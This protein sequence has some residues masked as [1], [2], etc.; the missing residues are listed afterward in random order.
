MSEKE[1]KG[2][3]VWQWPRDV[4]QWK[5][6]FEWLLAMTM[7]SVCALLHGVCFNVQVKKYMYPVEH[8]LIW[9]VKVRKWTRKE[10]KKSLNSE[11]SKCWETQ[12]IHRSCE[13]SFS[14]SYITWLIFNCC[15]SVLWSFQ[16]LS[17]S[18]TQ[19]CSSLLFSLLIRSDICWWVKRW[20]ESERTERHSFWKLRATSDYCLLSSL[21]PFYISTSLAS[22][23]ISESWWESNSLLQQKVSYKD[24]GRGYVIRAKP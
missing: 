19:C 16:F 15:F 13:N 18:Y 9:Q 7:M 12:R 5:W 14:L 11:I 17:F 23:I 22:F 4:L 20:V 10:A 2:N 8:H 21:V 24:M 1:T 3:K 6:T